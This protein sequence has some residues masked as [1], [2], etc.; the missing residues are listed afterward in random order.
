[1]SRVSACRVTACGSIRQ[2]L[3]AS[4]PCRKPRLMTRWRGPS[5]GST[6][7]DTSR[8]DDRNNITSALHSDARPALIVAALKRELA[9]VA[10]TRQTHLALL[11]TGEGP[12]NAERVLRAWLDAH[13]ARAV[14]NIGM[15]GALSDAF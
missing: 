1:R 9:V 15:A 10:R 7:M 14:I 4:L 6:I 11:E 8:A 3:C 2:R 13:Q 5:A 12:R